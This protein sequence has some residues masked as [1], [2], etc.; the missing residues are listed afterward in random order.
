MTPTYR[1]LDETGPDHAKVFTV[2]VFF[3]DKKAAEGSGQSK[4]D[5]E[6]AA[7]REALKLYTER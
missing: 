3:G 7:A 1:V 5:A 4:Q 2:G 6:T